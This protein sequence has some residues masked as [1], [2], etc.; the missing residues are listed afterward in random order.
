[1]NSTLRT[2]S[3]GLGLLLASLSF[4]QSNLSIP[5]LTSSMP[6]SVSYQV[7]KRER[8]DRKE[9]DDLVQRKRLQYKSMVSQGSISQSEAD[10][11]LK[12]LESTPLE[13]SENYTVNITLSK[14]R[15]L[16]TKIVDGN[17]RW[18]LAT[19]DYRLVYGWNGGEAI[20]LQSQDRSL[21]Y[22]TFGSIPLLPIQFES[23]KFFV[24]IRLVGS[25]LIGQF[26]PASLGSGK[27]ID[28]KFI[29]DGSRLE[30]IETENLER[31]SYQEYKDKSPFPDK[32]RLERN[33]DRAGNPQIT[34]EYKKVPSK[35]DERTLDDLIATFP[36]QV[37]DYRSD[38]SKTFSLRKGE[39][40]IE[41]SKRGVL[42]ARPLQ[43]ASSE[44]GASVF[45]LIGSVSAFSL[46]GLIAW[47]L[48][49]KKN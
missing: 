18:I 46:I 20:E 37:V 34:F 7:Y 44:N 38:P 41:A 12:N 42:V 14:D 5:I 4:A 31:W 36:V 43:T 39:S 22:E 28:T 23:Q 3:L 16:A 24:D 47:R 9:F 17:T 27:F 6:I 13:S 32:I 15:Q 35:I 29:A 45:K 10:A 19:P 2:F 1:M 11:F 33:F 8:L 49:R 21:Y 40:I 30:S 25:E 48:F 26:I